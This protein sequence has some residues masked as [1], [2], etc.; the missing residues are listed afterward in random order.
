[1]QPSTGVSWKWGEG[2]QH[3][4]SHFL[5]SPSHSQAGFESHIQFFSPKPLFLHE[6]ALALCPLLISVSSLVALYLCYHSPPLPVPT[7][8]DNTPGP[9][10]CPASVAQQVLLCHNG[11]SPLL[12][13]LHA[14]NSPKHSPGV[15]DTARP[16]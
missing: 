4:L 10:Q 8:P 5:T 14:S 13:L 9:C 16:R 1:M 6:E 2:T 11:I 12:A 7:S 15:G 3:P